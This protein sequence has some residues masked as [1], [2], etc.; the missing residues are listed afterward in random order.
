MTGIISLLSTPPILFFH[1]IESFD[2]IR[3]TIAVAYMDESLQYIRDL[4][5]LR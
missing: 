5:K 3:F 1:S 2:W 4:E